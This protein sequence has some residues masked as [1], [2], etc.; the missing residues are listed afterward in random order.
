MYRYLRNDDDDR[1]RYV[2]NTHSIWSISVR[3]R[4]FTIEKTNMLRIVP[5]PQY[6]LRIILIVR[7]IFQI[8]NK[9]I[10][11]TGTQSTETTFIREL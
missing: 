8:T 10:T 5:Y 6:V 11:S 7:V 9:N 3:R 1:E 4:I 2:R